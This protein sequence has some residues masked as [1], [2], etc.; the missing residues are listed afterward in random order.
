MMTG[1]EIAAE[2]FKEDADGN[3]FSNENGKY[4]LGY[5]KHLN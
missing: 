2:L 1:G 5:H 4:S 3:G